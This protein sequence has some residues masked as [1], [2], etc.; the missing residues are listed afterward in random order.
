M[1]DHH[2]QSQLA[3]IHRW[4]GSVLHESGPLPEAVRALERAVAIEEVLVRDHPESVLDR[5]Q[6]AWSLQELGVEQDSIG[7]PDQAVRSLRLSLMVL[8]GLA[9]DDPG[10][11]RRRAD[12]DWCRHDLA[13]ALD[14]AGRS[15]ESSAHVRRTAEVY[16]ELARDHPET[17]EYRF[18]LGVRLA[19]LG[20]MERRAGDP[21]SRQTIERSL[22]LQ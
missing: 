15:T 8:E 20:V 4:I 11:H 5:E 14:S 18:R 1:A 12:V 22:V 19:T 16:E 21:R 9:R 10:S 7:R 3:R 2:Q 13:L 6:L 17:A